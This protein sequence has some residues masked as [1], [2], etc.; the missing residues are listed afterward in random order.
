M[1]MENTITAPRDAVIKSIQVEKGKTV[2]KNEVII[3]LE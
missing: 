3:E 2:S 1:K